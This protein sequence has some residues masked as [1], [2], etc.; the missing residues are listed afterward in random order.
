G[1]AAI[2]DAWMLAQGQEQQSHEACKL[3]PVAPGATSEE[4][5]WVKDLQQSLA[6]GV[7]CVVG[8]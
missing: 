5:E 2:A 6:W 1:S 8:M 3:W 4:Q 7:L